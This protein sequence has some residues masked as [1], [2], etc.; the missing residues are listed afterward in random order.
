MPFGL[1]FGAMGQAQG[2]ADWVIIGISIF[3]FAGASQFIA[4]TMLATGAALPVI[5]LKVFNS[6]SL[7]ANATRCRSWSY[8][9]FYN[10]LTKMFI[11]SAL[12]YGYC[13]V[14]THSDNNYHLDV[15]SQKSIPIIAL[16]L[17]A[18]AN[19][20]Y[21]IGRLAQLKKDRASPFFIRDGRGTLVQAQ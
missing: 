12:G 21:Q 9:K 18:K 4:I 11:L 1:V 10:V 3:V 13:L 16:H 19:K 5:V 14:F 15:D 2:L 7:N 8:Q 17:L 6:L 20:Q